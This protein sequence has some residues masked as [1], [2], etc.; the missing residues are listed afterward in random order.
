MGASDDT[1][2]G[3]RPGRSFPYGVNIRRIHAGRY[4][5]MYE[6]EDGRLTIIVFHLGRTR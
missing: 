4:R 3:L 1:R 2:T 5:V 6:I